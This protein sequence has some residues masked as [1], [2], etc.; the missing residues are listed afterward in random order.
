MQ[1]CQRIFAHVLCHAGLDVRDEVLCS[2]SGRER[3]EDSQAT[4]IT[5]V[6]EVAV[7]DDGHLEANFSLR[8]RVVEEAKLTS[9]PVTPR[10]FSNWPK[11]VLE[12]QFSIARKKQVTH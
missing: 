1:Q 7:A 9:R 2:S 8:S 12:N 3:L 5:H 10:Y 6:V 11:S 4:Y